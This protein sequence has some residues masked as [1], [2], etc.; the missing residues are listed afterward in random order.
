MVLACLARL[1]Y[2]Q[3]LGFWKLRHIGN[4]FLKKKTRA[5]K[6]LQRNG[7]SNKDYTVLEWISMGKLCNIITLHR[8]IDKLKDKGMGQPKSWGPF[9][10]IILLFYFIGFF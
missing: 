10:S 7:M 9:F 5:E 6:L 2:T 1:I 4:F 8:A 3:S